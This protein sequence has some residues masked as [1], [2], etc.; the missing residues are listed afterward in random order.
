MT[1]LASF[2]GTELYYEDEGERA[3]RPVVL[4]HGLS[5]SIQGN[6]REPGIWA[7]LVAAGRRVIGLD[8]RGHGRSAKP[9]DPSAYENDAMTTDVGA[10]LDHLGLDQ[11]D[12]VGYSMGAGTA[13][14]FAIS[15]SPRLRRLVLGGIG[16]DPAKWG[17]DDDGGRSA[18]VRRWLTGIEATD[19]DAIEDPVARRARKIFVARGNDLEAIAALLRSSRKHLSHD[20]ALSA[21]TSPTLVV[22]GD[23]DTDPRPLA[24]ALP[25]GESLILEGD[26]ESV[27]GNPQLAKSIV[28]F[29]SD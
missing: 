15:D 16:G 10:L 20:M 5:S 23:K 26:H 1:Q 28:H 13:L 25:H 24:A 29:L 8:A 3:G 2:D 22:C 6:W 14:Q 4:L 7:E 17:T 19:P 9:H 18:T 27:V 12:L 21:V 11:V